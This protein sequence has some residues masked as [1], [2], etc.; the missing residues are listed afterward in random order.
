MGFVVNFVVN[1][2]EVS[3]RM[4][5]LKIMQSRKVEKIQISVYGVN[6]DA[7]EMFEMFNRLYRSSRSF[8]EYIWRFI[9]SNYNFKN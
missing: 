7:S 3:W 5:K 1:W 4:R 2:L 6:Y 8:F 9:A